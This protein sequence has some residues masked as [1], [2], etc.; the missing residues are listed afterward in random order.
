MASTA[1]AQYAASYTVNAVG[2]GNYGGSSSAS[3]SIT[4]KNYLGDV[5]LT[6]ADINARN[7]SASH[8]M[9]QW[10]TAPNASYSMEPL[11]GGD[12]PT[13][14]SID[15]NTGRISVASTAANQAGQAYRVTAVGRALWEGWQK[16]TL[17]IGV[18]DGLYYDSRP[19]LVDQL[20]SLEVNSAGVSSTGTYSVSPSL[21]AGLTI[22]TSTGRISGTPTARQL[23]KDYTI[24]VTPSSGSAI[25]IPLSLMVQE[26]PANKQ[27]LWDIIDEEIGSQG[28]DADLVAY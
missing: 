16:T 17:R 4:V 12:L 27:E 7:G 9:P 10:G 21:P 13:G 18:H 23:P 26:Q 22:N 19:A 20:Y 28:N 5:S 11:S 3:I 6:Y 25:T 14:V 2:I 15:E 1:P 24:T 8:S